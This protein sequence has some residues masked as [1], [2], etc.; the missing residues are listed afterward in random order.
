MV[1]TIIAGFPG[2][3]KTHFT[4]ADKT[5]RISDSDSFPFEDGLNGR[6]FPQNYI[7]YLKT[8]MEDYI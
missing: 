7:N 2:V 4:R 1:A 5:H 8:I 6:D 3:G